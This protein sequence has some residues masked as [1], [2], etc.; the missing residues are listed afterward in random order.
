MDA[1]LPLIS[2]ECSEEEGDPM[3]MADITMEE[4]HAPTLVEKPPICV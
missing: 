1:G 4:E 2:S 3:D